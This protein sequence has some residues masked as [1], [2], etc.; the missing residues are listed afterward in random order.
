MP[1]AFDY[2]ERSKAMH[3][4]RRMNNAQLQ[5]MALAQKFSQDTYQDRIREM[6]LGNEMSA[7]N[8]L[9]AQ[10]KNQL[11]RDTYDDQVAAI[12]LGNENTRSAIDHRAV[13]QGHEAVRQQQAK[14]KALV[15]QNR[16]LGIMAR[17]A[18]EQY[19]GDP[20]AQAS[21]LAQ[22]AKNMGFDEKLI[23]AITPESVAQ[24][25]QIPA[26]MN[27]INREMTPYQSAQLQARER[28]RELEQQRISIAQKNQDLMFRGDRAAVDAFGKEYGASQG[29]KLAASQDIINQG[30]FMLGLIDKAIAHPGREAGTGTSAM[31]PGV[32]RSFGIATEG[33]DFLALKDQLQGNV[34]LQAY[35]GLKG[36]GQ[37][38]EIEGTKAENAIARL[39]TAQTDESFLEALN[40]LKTVI[41]LG[42][43]RA[44]N[45]LKNSPGDLG[46]GVIAPKS[47][48][49]KRIRVDAQGNLL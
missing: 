31:I 46:E 2:Y 14:Q 40:D 49:P 20:V 15:D 12:G 3:E 33:G 30:D 11:F 4:T 16:Y 37:I 8:V 6:Q 13:M 10:N 44:R 38:T 27:Q 36:A 5:K 17:N 48:A 42:T 9:T 34:F 25:S 28:D 45:R 1:D 18:M 22:N 35:E 47:T 19:E 24:F 43:N 29:G 7:A 39:Q 23:S 32:A 21:A 26:N 41:T